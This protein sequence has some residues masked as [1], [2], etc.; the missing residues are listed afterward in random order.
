LTYYRLKQ[1]DFDGK[2]TYSKIINVLAKKNNS[3]FTIFPNPTKGKTTTL[4]LNED[5]VDGTLTVT[6]AIGS[7]VKKQ[8]INSKTLTLD[9]STLTNGVYIFD[10]Q[11]GANHYFEKVMVAE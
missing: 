7:I 8:T 5:M 11:K 3:Q 1:V 6:N 9:L 10:I 2:A 4:E